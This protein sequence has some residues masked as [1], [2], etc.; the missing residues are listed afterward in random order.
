MQPHRRGYGERALYAIWP[1][2][3]IQNTRKI[4]DIT[5][6][7]IEMPDVVHPASAVPLTPTR[8]FRA[9]RVILTPASSAS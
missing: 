3:G 1:F 9:K 6:K 5:F 7:K 8:P 4:P 2:A